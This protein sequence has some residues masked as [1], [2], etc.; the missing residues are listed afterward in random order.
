MSARA[1]QWFASTGND[2]LMQRYH[3]LEWGT[4]A[5]LSWRT[6][7]LKREGYRQ[8]FDGIDPARVAT[9]GTAD[10]ERLLADPGIIRNALK[11]RSA[12]GNAQRFRLVH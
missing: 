2:P 8:A 12:I 10:V 7:L 6:V 9:Y 11:V 3:Y 1:V 5:S 4:P